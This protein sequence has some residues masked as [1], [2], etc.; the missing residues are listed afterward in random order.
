MPKDIKGL[1][2]KGGE[3]FFAVRL[4]SNVDGESPNQRNPRRVSTTMC[5]REITERDCKYPSTL[6]QNI[7]VTNE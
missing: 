2:K 4:H 1:K 3:E 6:T 7:E 5:R